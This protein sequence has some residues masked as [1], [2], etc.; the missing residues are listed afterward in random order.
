MPRN[1][2]V[3]LLSPLALWGCG[4]GSVDDTDGSAP[5]IQI[6]KPSGATVADVVDFAANVT[7]DR[8]VQVVEF[9]VDDVLLASDFTEPFETRWNTVTSADGPVLLKVV[10]RDFSGNQSFNSKNVTVQ[11]SPN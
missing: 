6:T 2:L 11:N 5:I 4:F 10:A 9:Y 1:A 8:G 7:D 3:L